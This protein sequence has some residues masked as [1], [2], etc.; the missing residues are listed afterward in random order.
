MNARDPVATDSSRDFPD[1]ADLV[2]RAAA[3]DRAAFCTLVRRYHSII[4][5]W[6]AVSLGDQDEAE[7]VTQQVLIKVHRALGSYRGGAKFTTWL[8]R[9]TRNVL[10]ESGRRQGRRNSLLRGE[11]TLM[12]NTPDPDGEAG[13]IDAGR[14]AELVRGYTSMLP[15]RQ[16][17]VFVLA[18]MEG[19]TPAEIAELL[20]VEQVTV[21]TNL[22]KARRAIRGRMLREQPKL[23]EEYRS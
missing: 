21:R 9:I 19:F 14:I 13:T 11:E 7:D 20:D 10:L 23:M 12:V 5:R 2:G 4:H 6:A 3:G 18:D 15:P 17:E 1:T 8:Y 22:L 16:R